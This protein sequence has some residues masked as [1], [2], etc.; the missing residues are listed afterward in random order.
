MPAN[1]INRLYHLALFR[2]ATIDEQTRLG[3][4]LVTESSI[5]LLLNELSSSPER[6][7]IEKAVWHGR[8]ITNQ[9]WAAP[10]SYSSPIV[11]VAEIDHNGADDMHLREIPGI[12]LDLDQHT[13]I[14]RS[15]IKAEG[16]LW[17]AGDK[18][19]RRY[20]T[21]NTMFGGVSAH[22][23]AMALFAIRPR[24]YIEI[25]SGYSSAVVLDCNDE[26]FSENPIQCTFIDPYPERLLGLLR[27]KDYSSATIKKVNVQSISNDVFSTLR[28]GDILFIDSTHVLKAGSDLSHELFRIIPS[29]PSGVYIHF[30]DIFYPFDYPRTWLK[31][32]NRSWNEAY[33]LRAFLMYNTDF[34]VHFWTDFFTLFAHDVLKETG[35]RHM[36][37]S[38]PSS[39][40]LQRV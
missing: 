5:D 20:N 31:E 35:A 6:Q 2:K 36:A 7:S 1:F 29:L 15:W 18:G 34:K 3:E 40:W 12:N 37:N 4:T 10:G 17:D 32:Q 25:G 23:L 8:Q 30:H 14:W 9:L 16:G 19:S 27:E 33:F 21:D 24:R 28:S 26:F 11:N 38:R 13:A 39:L 22:L